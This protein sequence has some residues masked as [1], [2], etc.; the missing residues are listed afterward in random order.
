[1]VLRRDPVP[2]INP[3]V[4]LTPLLF[5]VR[6]RIAAGAVKKLAAKPDTGLVTK[7]NQIHPLPNKSALRPIRSQFSQFQRVNIDNTLVYE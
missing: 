1:M 5:H 7:A 6:L 4:L 3:L 2:R